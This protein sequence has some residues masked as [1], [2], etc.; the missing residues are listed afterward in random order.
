MFMVNAICHIHIGFYG[1]SYKSL[2]TSS[3]LVYLGVQKKKNL[4]KTWSKVW[5]WPKV[6]EV[7]IRLNDVKRL[8]VKIEWFR[9]LPCP[10]KKKRCAKIREDFLHRC[11]SLQE[12][13]DRRFSWCESGLHVVLSLYFSMVVPV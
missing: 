5:G 2:C 8:L 10:S 13:R 1:K 9:N 7:N 11:D 6:S 3:G 12:P 4:R